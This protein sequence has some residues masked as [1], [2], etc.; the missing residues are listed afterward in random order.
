MY[1]IFKK[2]GLNPFKA[3][4]IKNKFNILKTKRSLDG[5]N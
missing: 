1:N 3:A 4:G 5:K 2:S